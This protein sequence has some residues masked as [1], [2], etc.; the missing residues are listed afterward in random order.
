M[1][2]GQRP[3]T[4]IG[5]ASTSKSGTSSPEQNLKLDDKDCVDDRVKVG[6]WSVTCCPDSSKYVT[7]SKAPSVFQ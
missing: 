6:G 1:V 3:A 2:F 7:P 4:V 5:F